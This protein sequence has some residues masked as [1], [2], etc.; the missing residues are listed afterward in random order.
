MPPGVGVEIKAIE[1]LR[2]LKMFVAASFFELVTLRNCF[3]LDV[4][5]S[6]SGEVGYLLAEYTL[7]SADMYFENMIQ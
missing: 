2:N 3:A 6:S 4:E 5:V 7:F 1:N